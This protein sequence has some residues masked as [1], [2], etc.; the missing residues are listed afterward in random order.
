VA[1]E[2]LASFFPPPLELQ[3]PD[4]TTGDN[5][6]KFLSRG[7]TID[8]L[9]RALSAANPDRAA[10]KDGLTIRVW[11]E[12]WPVLQHQICQLFSASLSQCKLPQERRVAK[13]IPLKK[14]VKDDY[15]LPESYRP[16]SLLTT[17]EKVMEAVIATWIA[18][19][20]EVHKL[21]ANN[22]L[23]ARKQKSTIHAISYLQEFIFNA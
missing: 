20:T 9:E 3:Q 13:I 7:L 2:L 6:E 5:A 10:G 23:G 18:Y 16:I 22:H 17:P 15:T 21:L 4:Q 12:V 19:L 14:D 8:E 11:R 1:K